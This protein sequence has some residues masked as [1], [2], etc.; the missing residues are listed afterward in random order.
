[1]RLRAALPGQQ[2]LSRT[3]L[4]MM[5]QRVMSTCS[6]KGFFF[7]ESRLLTYS[8][9]FPK[10][11]LNCRSPVMQTS[12]PKRNPALVKVLR[13]R[14]SPQAGAEAPELAS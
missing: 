14:T 4:L 9:I 12:V 10:R 8:F 13:P 6:R 2:G 1:M 3:S 11:R 7:N 5:S